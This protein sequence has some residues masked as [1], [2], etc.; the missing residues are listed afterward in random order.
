[1]TLWY[2]SPD[3][4]IHMV[5]TSVNKEEEEE[6]KGRRRRWSRRGEGEEEEI[7]GGSM[8][9]TKPKIFAVWSFTQKAC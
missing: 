5:C 1:M 3:K 2:R 6:R 7:M 8:W 9:P 4:L